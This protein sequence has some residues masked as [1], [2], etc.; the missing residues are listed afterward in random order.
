MQPDSEQVV[1]EEHPIKFVVSEAPGPMITYTR[2]VSRNVILVL[3]FEQMYIEF[4]KVGKL[5]Y[6]FVCFSVV[7]TNQT[8]PS[9]SAMGITSEQ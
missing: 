9:C 4:L 8:Y 3:E 6:K 2:T 5:T 1:Q 7:S